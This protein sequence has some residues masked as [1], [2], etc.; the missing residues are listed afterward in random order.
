MGC[1]KLLSCAGIFGSDDT[2]TVVMDTSF[3]EK[4]DVDSPSQ[5][6][7]ECMHGREGCSVHHR[8]LG[9]QVSND[10]KR[11]GRDGAQ[12]YKNTAMELSS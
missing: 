5:V 8:Y 2:K 11:A 6:L 12:K 9:E 4:S 7:N 3:R 1:P 10:E